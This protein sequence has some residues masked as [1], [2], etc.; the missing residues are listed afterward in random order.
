[1]GIRPSLVTLERS[2]RDSGSDEDWAAA[3]N[4]GRGWMLQMG[5]H[6]LDIRM[7]NLTVASFHEKGTWVTGRRFLR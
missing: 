6:V 5:L 2:V 7:S 1:M 3:E 4:E